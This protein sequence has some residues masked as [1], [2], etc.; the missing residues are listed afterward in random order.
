MHNDHDIIARIKYI[1][2]ELGYK[3]NTLAKKL[4][5]DN[6]NLSKYLNGHLSISEALLNRLVVNL[7]VSKA[8]LLTGGDVP[9]AKQAAAGPPTIVAPQ[10][11]EYSLEGTPVYDIDV[12][13]GNA[14]RAQ[15]FADEHIVG[16]I[17]LPDLAG[18]GS[19]IVRVSGDSL[20]PVIRNGDMIA[21]RELSSTRYIVWGQIY[22][23]LLDDYRLVKYIRKNPDAQLVTLHSENPNYDDIDV[24][25]D[26]LRDLMYVQSII[27]IDNRN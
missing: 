19:R 7:G 8:W 1:M 13:A 20:T 23:I 21:V 25:R 4:G 2:S 27:H 3:Q 9:Y 10:G 5:V 15:L 6:S 24:R 17:N 12:T 18:T 16:S 26:D 14:P 11:I 22:V